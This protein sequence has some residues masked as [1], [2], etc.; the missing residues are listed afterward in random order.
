MV[1]LLMSDLHLDL[2]TGL[3]EMSNSDPNRTGYVSYPVDPQGYTPIAHN[4]ENDPLPPTGGE[5]TRSQ[6]LVKPPLR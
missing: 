5:E 3:S 2:T 4:E 1:P 6:G